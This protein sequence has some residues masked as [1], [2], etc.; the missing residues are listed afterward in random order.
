MRRHCPSLEWFPYYRN[1][2]VSWV[3]STSGF[4]GLTRKKRYGNVKCCDKTSSKLLYRRLRLHTGNDCLFSVLTRSHFQVG[5]GFLGVQEG[6]APP[7][8]PVAPLYVPTN[9]VR[10]PVQ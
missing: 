8:S 7:P 10:V 6:V 3:T 1:A 4:I 5:K 2:F 9:Q